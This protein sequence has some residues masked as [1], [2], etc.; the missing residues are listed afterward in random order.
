MTE[1]SVLA[2][3][4]WENAQEKF[5][6]FIL[7]VIGALCAYLSQHIVPAPLAL[8]T[9]TLELISLIILIASAIA[10]FLRLEAA[11]NLFSVAHQKL[12]LSEKKGQLV[13]NFQGSSMLNTQTGQTL[14]PKEVVIEVAAIDK[15]L[16][17]LDET[18]ESLK[19]KTVVLYKARNYLLLIGFLLLVGARLLAAYALT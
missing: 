16:P 5:D 11:V 14:T 9:G 3:Q 17:V 4:T 1:R 13:S 2:Y 19:R 6:Y 15:A 8:N 7:G 12:S 18:S 10:G